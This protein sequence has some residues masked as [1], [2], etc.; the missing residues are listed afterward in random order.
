MWDRPPGLSL[1]CIR[2][3]AFQA[4]T[5]APLPT[6]FESGSPSQPAFAKVIINGDLG[7]H[8]GDAQGAAAAGV[9]AGGLCR[10]TRS[11]PARGRAA[12]GARQPVVHEELPPGDFAGLV[13]ASG[14]RGRIATVG[15]H[16]Q[17]QGAAGG[18]YGG[19]GLLH[20][21]RL[22]RARYRDGDGTI[23]SGSGPPAPGREA[24]S[25]SHRARTQRLHADSG[26]DRPAI[27]V[28]RDRGRRSG[29]AL[30]D[31]GGRLTLLPAP[32]AD[33][34]YLFFRNVQELQK[35]L[36]LVGG[37]ALELG[38]QAAHIFFR[39]AGGA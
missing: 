9:G 11:T 13:R 38:V 12:R 24:G 25:G 8:A 18:R 39:E 31:G 34:A 20:L 3:V 36:V 22:R 37:V 35:F 32:F 6:F 2:S 5:S 28:P 23:C 14:D 33:R 10:A 1:R 4:A 30:A 17:S 26:K 19:N 29:L 7:I 21:S 16:L 15:W 27:C